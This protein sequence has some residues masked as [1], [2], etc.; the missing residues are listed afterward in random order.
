MVSGNGKFGDLIM[1]R[2]A[3]NERDAAASRF[4]SYRKV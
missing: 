3:T 4:Y 2:G 1:S